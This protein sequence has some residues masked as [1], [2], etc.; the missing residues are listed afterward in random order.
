MAEHIP[1]HWVSTPKTE[2]PLADASNQATPLGLGKEAYDFLV[3]KIANHRRLLS[4]EVNGYVGEADAVL[5]DKLT[6]SDSDV[7][8][9]LI[10]CEPL[11]DCSRKLSIVGGSAVISCDS[12]SFQTQEQAEQRDANCNECHKRVAGTVVRMLVRHAE[13]VRRTSTELQDTE[14]ETA[15]RLRFL[16]GQLDSLL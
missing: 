16:R 9:S 14:L 3:T 12:V 8:Y 6:N 4:D 7:P 1:E 11:E 2:I 13:D 15:S 5:T 10:M